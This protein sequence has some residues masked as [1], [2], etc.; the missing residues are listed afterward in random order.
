M[1]KNELKNLIRESFGRNKKLTTKNA[2]RLAEHITL[3]TERPEESKGKSV[4]DKARKLV[5]KLAAAAKVGSVKKLH[6]LLDTK[7]GL[8]P[9][10]GYILRGG[11]E[12]DG[13][14]TDDVVEITEGTKTVLDLLPTQNEIDFFKSTS[15]GLSLWKSC[16][17]AHTL[18]GPKQGGPI[19]VSGNLVLDG[20]HRWSGCFALNPYGKIQVRDFKFPKGID[21]DGQKLCALQ[22]AVAS[23][24][25]PGSKLPSASAGAGTNILGASKESI[26]NHFNT[27]MLKVQESGQAFLGEKFVNDMKASAESI[28]IAKDLF[29]LSKEEIDLA[30]SAADI[31]GGKRWQDCPVRGKI[32]NVVADN[33]AGLPI[34]DAAPERADMP[35]LDHKEIGGSSGFDQLRGEMQA[36]E[37]NL[38]A[39]FLENNHIDLSRWNKLAGLLKD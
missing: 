2:H 31:D 9:E 21:G 12:Y 29:G 36:G 27:A 16:E 14:A 4:S 10:L 28:K 35:Q 5:D 25:K 34:N 6:K 3:L 7:E 26:M 23:K 20:H 37:I 15:W 24:R 19:S 33:L 39:P 8:S 17:A 13:N 1:R 38:A 18:W 30:F 22:L 11:G 32:A